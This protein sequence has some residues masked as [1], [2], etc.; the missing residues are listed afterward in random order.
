MPDTQLIEGRRV[1]V[2]EHKPPLPQ[3]L[4]TLIGALQHVT[5]RTD[6]AP[7]GARYSCEL[8]EHRFTRIREGRYLGPDAIVRDLR[9]EMCRDCGGVQVRDIS[10]MDSLDG[11]RVPT[12]RRG[13]SRV[14]QVLGWYS[15]ARPAGREY[16]R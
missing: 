1:Q 4:D 10:V 3:R 2:V 14:S 12:G 8:R 15:G 6:F 7:A 16:H 9:I 11:E 5:Y 13:P